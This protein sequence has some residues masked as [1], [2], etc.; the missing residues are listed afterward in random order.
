MERHERDE[1]VSEPENPILDET[2]L[3]DLGAS[4]NDDRSFVVELIEAFLADGEQHLAAI[5]TGQ[6]NGDVEALVRPAHTLKSS[7]AT[8]GAMRLSATARELEMA[9][10]SGALDAATSERVAR[11]HADWEA[12]ADAL[13]AWVTGEER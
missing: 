10:R 6:A 9:G 11:L 5:E 3:R 12:S 8:V 2:V 7:S 4:V 13:R 1:P